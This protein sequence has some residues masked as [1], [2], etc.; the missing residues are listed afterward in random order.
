MAIGGAAY[1]GLATKEALP[2]PRAPTPTRPDA[3]ATVVEGTA[4]AVRATLQARI[5]MATPAVTLPIAT[6]TPPVPPTPDTSPRIGRAYASGNWEYTITRVG[7]AK[8]IG[9][10]SSKEI[11]K[12]EFVI[13]GLTLKNIGKENFA[14]NPWDFELYDANGVKYNPASVYASGWAKANGYDGL[15]GPDTAQMRPGVPQTGVLFFDVAPGSQGLSL[16][17]VRAKADVP[18]Q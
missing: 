5:A 13:V 2:P 7:R 15:V 9:S 4:V 3:E 18:L 14:I 11:A 16:R 1:V 10:S 12:G 6:P 17:L 8:E